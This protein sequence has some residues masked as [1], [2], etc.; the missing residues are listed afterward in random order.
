MK[1]HRNEEELI[2]AGVFVVLVT[3]GVALG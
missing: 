2:R 1:A 3:Q